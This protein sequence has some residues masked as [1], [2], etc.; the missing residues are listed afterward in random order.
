MRLLQQADYHVVYFTAP[1]TAPRGDE[2]RQFVRA[3]S[4]AIELVLLRSEGEDI[5][6]TSESLMALVDATADMPAVSIVQSED[7]LI[8]MRNVMK[9]WLRRMQSQLTSTLQWTSIDQ[10]GVVSQ[11]FL[12]LVLRSSFSVHE[13]HETSQHWHMLHS[14]MAHLHAVHVV[15]IDSVDGSVVIGLP[16]HA[17]IATGDYDSVAVNMH[18]FL[19]SSDC[20]I[21]VKCQNKSL[22]FEFYLL[23]PVGKAF[24]AENPFMLY[25]L[26]AGGASFHTRNASVGTARARHIIH[27]IHPKEGVQPIRLRFR[28]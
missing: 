15:P 26:A 12:Q 4:A 3:S 8:D 23:V 2:L 28:H 16:L 1:T 20:A 6:G 25:R 24:S 13:G 27:S 7:S 14:G 22:V 17:T 9:P 5:H 21:V 10:E 19:Q 11:S 18:Y